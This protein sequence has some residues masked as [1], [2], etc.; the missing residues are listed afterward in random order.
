MTTAERAAAQ[1]LTSLPVRRADGP[2]QFAFADPLR[3]HTIL[4]DGGWTGIDLRPVD[5]EC[6]FPERD[7]IR[8]F[9]RLGPVGLILQ[10]A[11]DRVRTQ[12]IETVRE[13]FDPFVR[14]EEVRFSAACWMVTA[15]SRAKL[16]AVTA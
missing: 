7:L 15:H 16:G 6:A 14:G 11:E 2:G 12:V 13:A 5:V 10:E 4:R 9:T 8:Y 3:V 1:F